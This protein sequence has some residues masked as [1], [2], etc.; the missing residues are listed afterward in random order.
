MAAEGGTGPW[1]MNCRT[2][3]A[4]LKG[5]FRRLGVRVF[6]KT[7]VHSERFCIYLSGVVAW[8]VAGCS[9][10]FR[11]GRGVEPSAVAG[12]VS[13]VHKGGG[14]ADTVEMG[15][16]GCRL[17]APWRKGRVMKHGIA[18]IRTLDT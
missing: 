3:R 1:K 13:L 8:E 4:V 14:V 5:Y 7:C 2:I 11:P 18:A 12:V 16:V 15:G 10:L 17:S 6:E 9:V